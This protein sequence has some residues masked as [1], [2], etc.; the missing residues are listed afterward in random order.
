MFLVKCY[1]WLWFVISKIS[2]ILLFIKYYKII[3]N[4]FDFIVS[5]IINNTFVVIMFYSICIL[6]LFVFNIKGDVVSFL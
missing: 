5:I 4:K 1:Y 6:F 3:E 2:F